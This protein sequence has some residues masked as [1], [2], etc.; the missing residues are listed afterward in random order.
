[1]RFVNV[2]LTYLLTRGPFSK[3]PVFESHFSAQSREV[4]DLK[5]MNYVC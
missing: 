1:M 5:I 3:A 4:I 2:L